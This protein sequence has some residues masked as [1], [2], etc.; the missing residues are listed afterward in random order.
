M[1][2]PRAF[3]TG[4]TGQDGSYLTELLLEKG[5]EVHGLVRRSST[6][7]RSRIDHLRAAG[8]PVTLHYGDV[9]D[10][11]RLFG[12]I[13]EARPDEVY[14]LAAQSHVRVSFDDPSST[15]QVNGL[16]ALN[17]LEAVRQTKRPIKLY[18]ASSSEIFGQA[19]ESPQTEQTRLHPRSPY[20]CSKA[21]AHFQTINYREAYNLFAATGILYNHESPRRGENFVTRKISK[22]A[23]RIKMGLEDSLVLGDLDGQRDW[24]FA[25]DYV[26][27]MWL[28]LQHDIADDY[29][30]ATGIA[31]SV[32]DVLTEAFGRVDLDWTQ[33]VQHNSRHERPTEVSLLCGDASKA[34]KNL[35]WQPRHSFSEL[36]AMMVDADLEIARKDAL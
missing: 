10:A 1:T 26:E 8:K 25:G 35:G 12:L 9:L 23:A 16:G 32:R 27:A 20:A 24:G 18:Q 2:A 19:T 28:M 14:N 5:Y 21:Y 22:A 15:L 29:I 36:I 34:R 31:H 11:G 4:I 33:Y 3:I 13:Q 7:V 6:V 30:V 17:V